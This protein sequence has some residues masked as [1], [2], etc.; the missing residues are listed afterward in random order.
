MAVN[1]GR[2][3]VSHPN[4]NTRC[5]LALFLLSSV[6]FARQDW[7]ICGTSPTRDAEERALHQAWMQTAAFRRVQTAAL[8]APRQPAANRDVG[9][10]AIL[11]DNGDIIARPNG[12]DLIGKT[13]RFQPQNAAAS[14]YR[15]ETASGGYD[16]SLA[17]GT[18]LSLGDDDTR[19]VTIP[20]AFPF[21]GRTYT[22]VNVNS[23]GNLTFGEGDIS[24][25]ARTVARVTAGAPRIAVL[26]HD[27]DPSQR[28]A[29]VRTLFSGDRFIIS[30][31][32]VPRYQSLA[33]GPPQTFQVKLFANGRIEFS[34]D[35]V[36]TTDGIAGI[37][38]GRLQG[39][40]TLVNF[41]D[42][43]AADFTGPVVERFSS[44]QGIDMTLAAQ[45]FY[46]THE[47][48]YDYLAVY[49]NLN[50]D[51]DAGAV[52]YALT[53]RNLVTGINQEVIDLAGE[54]GSPRRLQTLMNFGQLSQ[55][56]TDPNGPV[57]RRG[58]TGDTPLSI[59]GHE[60]GH[61]FLAYAS[62]IDPATGGKPMLTADGAH[63]AFTFN[64]E[65]SLLQGN[66]IRD[67]GVGTS[68]RFLTTGTVEGYSPFDLYLM[69]FAMPKE[70]PPS[71]YVT[72]ATVSP[73]ALPQKGTGFDGVRRDV[74]IDDLI[75]A[76]N[77]PRVPDSTVSP[78]RFRMAF[79]LVTSAGGQPS[80][81][82]MAKLESFRSQFESYFMGATGSRATMETRLRKSA[83]LSFWPAAG[84]VEG[85]TRTAKLAISAP[86]MS[87]LS[88]S[89]QTAG[90]NIS[91]PLSVAIPAG[92][93][94]VQ[95]DVRGLQAGVGELRVEPDDPS[96]GGTTAYLQVLAAA[97]LRLALVSGD[98]QIA[99]PG[100]ALT[101][102]VR[103]QVTDGNTLSYEGVPVRAT[104][105]TGSITPGVVLSDA[106]GYVDFQWTPG[107]GQDQ[108]LSAAISGG[109]SA[110]ATADSRPFTSAAGIANA[111]SFA[112]GLVPGAIGSIFGA[113]L[114]A[115]ARVQGVPPLPTQLAGV[116]VTIGG[117]AAQL[118]YV[119]DNQINLLVPPVLSPG[120]TAVVVTSGA[121]HT[122]SV[123]VPILSVQPGI[124]QNS[125]VGA[126][127][128][129]PT[130]LEI[131]ATGLGAVAPAASGF[132][133]T[134]VRPQVTLGGQPV[135]VLY[136]GPAPTFPGLY[137]V[138]VSRP[139]GLTGTLNLQMTMSGIASNAVTV[140]LP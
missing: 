26:F 138:N 89:I 127:L 14:T 134:T 46:A 119:S 84:V 32:A 80:A 37:A 48:A 16:P 94:S 133:E 103:F 69:G 5:V 4:S 66:R 71:F 45:R 114:A 86:S 33:P 102:P 53:Y 13:L 121:L 17:Q 49:N 51:A 117:V 118:F 107:A 23:D 56:P 139:A 24:S 31:V 104:V 76:Q 106:S 29:S 11:E 120:T 10:I 6:A 92:A 126:V 50:I 15:Y 83:D 131:Y 25:E 111:A 75:A 79:I 101:K 81:A 105:T 116:S 91:A 115:G 18:D 57:A 82:D 8:N 30:W 60:T 129:Y 96:Y 73:S 88:F 36:V 93:R 1:R 54:S 85:A 43:S 97:N 42:A 68:P 3:F 12:F 47:D 136:S 55:Y 52:A 90:G 123:S 20:F 9:D 2:M 63:W 98:Q 128:I 140:T 137:Q 100:Q 22:S 38:P 61:R 124:F 41:T 64:S 108:R 21:F 72:G 7:V 19:Q 110:Q 27:M 99:T 113:N 28:G 87:P 135:N 122:A 67:N 39:S 112:L 109:A 65:A 78:R 74:S 59:I 58:G 35:T 40:V 44:V 34:Y 132:N 70:A 62:V 130:H 77:G 125:G 95:F